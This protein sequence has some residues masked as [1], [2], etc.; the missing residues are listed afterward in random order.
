MSTINI[1]KEAPIVKENNNNG[2]ILELVL[3]DNLSGVDY[4]KLEVTLEDNKKINSINVDK[5]TNKISIDLT[6]GT[7]YLKIFDN[8]G[9]ASTYRIDIE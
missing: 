6:K 2:E 8:V 9:N 7:K 4:D 3:S 5:S 1:D